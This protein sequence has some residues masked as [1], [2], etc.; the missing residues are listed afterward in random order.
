MT[1][2]DLFE[3]PASLTFKAVTSKG[4]DVQF[5]LRDFDENKLLDRFGKFVV[6]LETAGVHHNGSTPT[7]PTSKPA[8]PSFTP[9]ELDRAIE[10]HGLPPGV[11]P[12][13]AQPAQQPV[14]TFTAEVLVATMVDGKVYRKVKGGKFSRFGVTI[15]DEVLQDAG[16]NVAE[17]D[18]MLQYNL[19]GYVATYV[20]KEGKPHKV[21]KLTKTA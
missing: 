11:L 15:W 2:K 18:P 9:D 13:I 10:D 6:A 19:T 21:T 17:L 7:P 1:D 14:L 8:Q 3:A 20:E 16:F 4:W 5:T 12:T